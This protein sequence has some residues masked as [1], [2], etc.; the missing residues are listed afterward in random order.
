MADYQYDGQA[1]SQYVAKAEAWTERQA[2]RLGYSTAEVLAAIRRGWTAEDI[3]ALATAEADR[4]EGP[5]RLAL[6]SKLKDAP[7]LPVRLSRYEARC[8]ERFVSRP[9]AAA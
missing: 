9:R 8:H 6:A 2:E 5:P 4:L 7:V 1:R 3:E